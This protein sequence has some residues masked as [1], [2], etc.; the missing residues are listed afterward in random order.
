M[1]EVRG[2]L[3]GSAAEAGEKEDFREVSV[4]V[5]GPALESIRGELSVVLALAPR[6][7][8]LE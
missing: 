8:L 5:W 1:S 7:P 3:R 2:G 4:S 6:T